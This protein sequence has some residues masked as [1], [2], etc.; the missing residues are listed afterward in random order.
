MPQSILFRLRHF[1]SVYIIY[2]Y[3]WEKCTTSR[4]E[5]KNT[6]VC[7][8]WEHMFSFRDIFKLLFKYTVSCFTEVEITEP[9]YYF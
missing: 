3:V 2:T 5:K 8:E 6:A 9:I 7:K 1:H 4:N